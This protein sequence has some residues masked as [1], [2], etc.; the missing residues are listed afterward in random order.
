[1]K[2]SETT[3]GE[4]EKKGENIFH[5]LFCNYKCCVKFSYER[6]LLTHKHIYKANETNETKNETNETTKEKK[7]K[8][9]VCECGLVFNSRTTLWRH[10]KTCNKTSVT[11]SNVESIDKDQIIIMLIKQNAEFKNMMIEQ[12]NIMMKVIENGTNNT[13]ITHT[14]SHN[15]AFNLNFFLNETCKDAMN[16]TDF[17]DS[18]K[19]QLSD[20]EIVGEVGYVEGISNIIIKNLNE[21]DETKRPVHCTDKKRETIYIKDQGQWEK[22]DNKTILKKSINKIANKNIKLISQ[23]REKYPECRKSDSK[24]SDKYNKMIIEA[25]GGPGDNNV[26]KEEKII[27]NITKA[28]IINK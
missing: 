8:Q 28:T 26:E 3:L 13:N 27:R 6:H 5:C 16:I 23:F 18:I 1:M 12:Q 20:L 25:M 9:F 19:L 22:D 17:V 15:K 14:N 7:E 11:D 4:K 24:I 10:K 2:Q 21:L